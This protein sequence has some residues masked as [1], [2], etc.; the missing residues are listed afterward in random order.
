MTKK[1]WL[2]NILG[3]QNLGQTFFGQQKF[4]SK[5]C[6][7]KIFWVKNILGQKNF[8]RKKF[9]AKKNLPKKD[10]VKFYQKKTGSK[11]FYFTIPV[12]T[13]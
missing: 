9:G 2:K 3:Q 7:L 4:V 11:I 6:W 12:D 10:W 5:K 8:G 13:R 1:S